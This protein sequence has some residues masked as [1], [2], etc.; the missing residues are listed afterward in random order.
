MSKLIPIEHKDLMI[1]AY[2][3]GKSAKKSAEPFGYTKKTCLGEL[4]R[5]NITRMEPT[6]K[7]VCW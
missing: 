1:E 7:T 4:K 2:L 6:R 3:A 5:R